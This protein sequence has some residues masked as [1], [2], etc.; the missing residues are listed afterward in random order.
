MANV[1]REDLDKIVIRINEEM[2]SLNRSL[3]TLA[4]TFNEHTHRIPPIM[5]TS[6]YGP[7]ITLEVKKPE[8]PS[9]NE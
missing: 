6:T 5:A 9:T 4:Q 3:E 1:S 7:S 8:E 2:A